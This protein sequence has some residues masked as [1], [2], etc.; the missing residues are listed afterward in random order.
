MVEIVCSKLCITMVSMIGLK[1][2]APNV[3]GESSK[4]INMV[5]MLK[6]KGSDALCGPIAVNCTFDYSRGSS[7]LEITDQAN[8]TYVCNFDVMF[9]C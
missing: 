6:C 9:S 8:M 4:V 3:F 5:D 2:L 7:W 1:L